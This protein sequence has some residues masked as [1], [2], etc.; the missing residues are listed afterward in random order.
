MEV[1]SGNFAL[2]GDLII[3]EEAEPSEPHGRITRRIEW[4]DVL[5][6]VARD[7]QLQSGFSGKADHRW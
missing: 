4:N 6:R 2:S 7:S 5:V 3:A 1:G